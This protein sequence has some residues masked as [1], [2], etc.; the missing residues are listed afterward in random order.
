[1]LQ[2]AHPNMQQQTITAAAGT[3]CQHQTALEATAAA[4][5]AAAATVAV[6]AAAVVE[7]ASSR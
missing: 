2:M 6:A 3:K 5:A 7:A 1:M 4:V